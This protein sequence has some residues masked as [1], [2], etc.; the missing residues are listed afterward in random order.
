MA[1]VT[2]HHPRPPQLPNP[3]FVGPYSILYLNDA[4]PAGTVVIPQLRLEMSDGTPFTGTVTLEPPT[5]APP[6]PFAI[7]PVPTLDW[8]NA[9]LVL[10]RNLTPADD[11]ALNDPKAFVKIIARAPNGTVIDQPQLYFV[12]PN[13]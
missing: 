3:I 10:D 6:A 5:G 4:L 13:Y 12:G 11:S 9:Q 7:S 2:E 1:S 8:F